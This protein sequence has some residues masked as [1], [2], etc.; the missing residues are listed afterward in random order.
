MTETTDFMD[1]LTGS[2]KVRTGF[3]HLDLS[4]RLRMRA[5]IDICMPPMF[6]E[7]ERRF[8]M[9]SMRRSGIA[10]VLY[11]VDFRNTPTPLSFSRSLHT[12]FALRLYRSCSDAA[13]RPV[14]PGQGR[15]RLLFESRTRIRGRR[16]AG[17]R[18]SLGYGGAEGELAEAG[19]ARVLHVITRPAGAPGARE[20][21]ELPEALHGLSEHVWQAPLPSVDRLAQVPP[22]HAPVDTGGWETYRGVWGMPNTDV[23][24]HVNVLEYIMGLE[25]QYT[26]QLHAG[27]L[28]VRGHRISRAR[29]LFRKPFFPAQPY[30]IRSQLY[31]CGEET[32]M[33][34]GFY[35]IGEDGKVAQRPSVFAAM[36][37]ILTGD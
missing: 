30:L 2:A 33:V 32:L 6:G 37:G 9:N 24:Q 3:G 23:N 29:L 19:S 15:Q 20:V 5:F 16:H 1:S 11:F 4:F 10:S 31:R 17:D 35:L 18:K 14:A 28:P 13:G 12:E 7:L 25:N 34:G 27:N 26:R 8:P 22:D 21:T 36:E